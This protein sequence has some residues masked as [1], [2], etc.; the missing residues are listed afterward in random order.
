MNEEQSVPTKL[1]GLPDE[2][3]KTLNNLIAAGF[4][5]HKVKT[6]LEKKFPTF[7]DILPAARGTYQH[8]I[9]QHLDTLLAEATL[10]SATVD[11]I[12]DGFAN[13]VN[14]AD[15]VLGGDNASKKEQIENLK[16]FMVSRI[17]FLQRAQGTG[18]P[19]AQLENTIAS[20]VNGVRT[21]IE[22]SIEYGA[23][24]NQEDE[25][26]VEIYMESLIE[27]LIENTLNIYKD[28]HGDNK[29]KEF[30]IA[31]SAKLADTLKNA[32]Q[33]KSDN[34]GVPQT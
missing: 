8:Y 6:E 16:D 26:Q 32:L 15:A 28:F 31:L 10:Q 13:A 4:G 30:E 7:N 17:Q 21:L 12:A 20:Y 5:S 11:A 22:K 1:E 23:E 9:D 18:I 3:K 24:L 19:S 33:E 14:F 29:L 25:N 27:E 2:I 34:E